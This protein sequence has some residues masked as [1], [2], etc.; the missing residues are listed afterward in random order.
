MRGRIIQNKPGIK[1]LELNDGSVVVSLEEVGGL[2]VV[3]I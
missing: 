2:R 3:D 1:R